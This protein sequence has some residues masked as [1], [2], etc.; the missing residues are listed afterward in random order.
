MLFSI[1]VLLFSSLFIVFHRLIHRFSSSHSSLFIVHSSPFIVF[2]RLIHRFSSFTHRLKHHLFPS[3]RVHEHNP[4]GVEV[5]TVGAATVKV[6]SLDGSVQPFRVG[7]VHAQLVRA[8]CERMQLH[9]VF[10]DNEI[11]RNG[12]FTMLLIDLLERTVHQIGRKRQ[13]DATF[14]PY[15]QGFAI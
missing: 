8:A 4:R 7:A 15:R 14:H 6:L 9:N 1:I 5:E 13:L 2:H 12:R 3:H 10:I 11:L